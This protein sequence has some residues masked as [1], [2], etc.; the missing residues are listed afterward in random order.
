MAVPMQVKAASEICPSMTCQKKKKIEGLIMK[1][2]W[3][4]A[5]NV[6]AGF[7]SY[8]SQCH[9]IDVPFYECLS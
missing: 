3:T 5:N 1:I 8:Y 7:S 6:G 4:F 2:F 9:F